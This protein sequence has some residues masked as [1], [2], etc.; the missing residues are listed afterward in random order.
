MI[1]PLAEVINGLDANLFVGFR[2]KSDPGE[3]W[4]FQ[5]YYM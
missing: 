2:R 5:Q 4:F 1:Y 3:G